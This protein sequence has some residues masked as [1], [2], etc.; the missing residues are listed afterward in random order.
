MTGV[1]LGPDLEYSEIQTRVKP[2]GVRVGERESS[3]G[4]PFLEAAKIELGSDGLPGSF[5]LRIKKN[6][7]RSRTEKNNNNVKPRDMIICDSVV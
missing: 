2:G 5:N 3:D 4:E 6:W 1:P 7:Q